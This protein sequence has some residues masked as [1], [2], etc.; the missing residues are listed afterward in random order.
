[1]TDL[2]LASG[3][4]AKPKS[5]KWR[6]REAAIGTVLK[7][8][9]FDKLYF[10]AEALAKIF[11]LRRNLRLRLVDKY[12]MCVWR[13]SR[14]TVQRTLKK[15]EQLG[16]IKRLTEKPQ[17]ESGSG[18]SAKFSQ[19]RQIALL[20]PAKRK[21]LTTVSQVEPQTNSSKDELKENS[22]SNA[23]EGKSKEIPFEDYLATKQHIPL[24]SWLYW[25][26]KNGAVQESM[27]H[28]RNLH[29][30]IAHRPDLLESIL[31]DAQRENK[32]GQKL[33]GFVVTEIKARTGTGAAPKTEQ[34]TVVQEKIVY[35]SLMGCR[36]C[37]QKEEPKTPPEAGKMWA[38]NP[39][40]T[41]NF[42][43]EVPI[44]SKSFFGDETIEEIRARTAESHRI[45]DESF[46]K[47]HKALPPIEERQRAY[48]EQFDRA[49]YFD[50]MREERLEEQR[51]LNGADNFGDEFAD[52][53]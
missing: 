48:D 33:I 16:L 11:F 14:Q 24:K 7:D 40:P 35:N 19:K 49:Q 42:W 46:D 1:M 21:T 31:F 32:T 17:Y 18:K 44:P 15:L 23:G 45:R 20:L 2:S 52:S 38:W 39:R 51:R 12:L 4:P 53:F 5:H 27:G 29:Q 9:Q 37:H 25:C 3:F 36:E 28:L 10:R 50:N 6:N 26:R 41:E 8:S 43:I 13:C 30:Q 47:W 34:P 22:T